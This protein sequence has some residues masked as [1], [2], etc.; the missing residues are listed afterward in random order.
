MALTP[1]I[2]PFHKLYLVIFV[3]FRHTTHILQVA[4]VSCSTAIHIG[5]MKYIGENKEKM[6]MVRENP[7]TVEGTGVQDAQH[8][9]GGNQGHCV[10]WATAAWLS[11]S[12]IVFRDATSNGVTIY[13]LNK[14]IVCWR[15]LLLLMPAWSTNPHSTI[16][17]LSFTFAMPFILI[18]NHMHVGNRN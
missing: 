5:E 1:C 17:Q 8:L 2:W 10:R 9:L 16:Q 13:P 14:N 7:S 6:G 15:W 12:D 18:H 4:A 11:A 3:L